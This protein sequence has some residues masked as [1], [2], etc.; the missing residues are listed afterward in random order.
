MV[1][2]DIKKNVLLIRKYKTKQYQTRENIDSVVN[3]KLYFLIKV[4]L[5]H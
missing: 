2:E 5:A 3:F 4:L 1:I